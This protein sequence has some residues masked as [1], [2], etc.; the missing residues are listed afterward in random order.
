[1]TC[2]NNA[3][4]PDCVEPARDP[5]AAA[6]ELRCVQLERVLAL[7]GEAVAILDRESLSRAAAYADMA[8]NLVT[9]EVRPS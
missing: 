1:M 2:S 7:L 3:D 8:Q 6:A 5:H 9:H 4:K